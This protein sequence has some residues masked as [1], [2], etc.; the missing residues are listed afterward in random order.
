MIKKL[1]LGAVAATLACTV[2]LATDADTESL[3]GGLF[4]TQIQ[5]ANAYRQTIAFPDEKRRLQ[6]IDGFDSLAQK[7]M[8]PFLPGGVWGRGPLSNGDA[9][10]SCHLNSGRGAVPTKSDDPIRTLLLRV[11]MPGKDANGFPKPEPRYGHQ[12]NFMGFETDVPS[13]GEAYI[14]WQEKPVQFADGESVTLR[15]PT[16]RLENLRYGALARD[17][18]MSPRLAQPLIGMGLLEAISD[19]TLEG[20]EKAQ[21]PHG[22]KGKANRVWDIEQKR[23]AIGRFG[24]KASHP[25]LAQQIMAAFSEDLGVTSEL[26]PSKNCSDA[27]QG[28]LNASSAAHPELPSNQFVPLLF[29]LRAGAVPARRGLDDA[30]VKRGGALFK[31]AACAVCHVPALKTGEYRPIPEI[32]QQTIRPYTDLLLH[33]MGEGLADGREDFAARGSEW[34]TPPLWG[35]GLAKTVSGQTDFLHDGRARD[36]KEAILWHDGEAKFSRDAFI[37]MPKADRQALLKFLDS[38]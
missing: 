27:Q 38:L 12:F 15:V 33:D 9:C 13:E 7:W 1:L 14:D 35:L 17:A 19:A 6:F 37:N 16:Y 32:S 26:F 31:D 3:S 22:I 25:S 21:K 28:C 8:M 29:Y 20:L 2:A 10:Q 5:D 4:T 23:R 30:E 36:A 11:S 24:L 34:R 18:L